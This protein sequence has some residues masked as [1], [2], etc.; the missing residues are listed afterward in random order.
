MCVVP[1]FKSRSTLLI[2]PGQPSERLCLPGSAGKLTTG[3]E[4]SLSTFTDQALFRSSDS[5]LRD[6]MS[7]ADAAVHFSLTDK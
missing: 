4:R 2:G 3:S 5:A 6:K 1:L 7:R